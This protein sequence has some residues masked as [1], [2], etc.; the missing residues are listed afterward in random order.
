MSP[1]RQQ[2][3]SVINRHPQGITARRVAE[4]VNGTSYTVS[5]VCSKLFAYGQIRRKPIEGP[6]G[7][8][9]VYAFM[10]KEIRP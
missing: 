9:A 5:G 4:L 2:I 7:A 6:P 8:G 3:L 1:T 10:P